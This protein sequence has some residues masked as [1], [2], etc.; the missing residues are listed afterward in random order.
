MVEGDDLIVV[1]D[2]I[3]KAVIEV[4]EEGTEAV[5]VTMVIDTEGCAMDSAERSPPQVN[6]VADHPFAFYIVE[7][8]TGAVVFAGHVLDPS[9]EE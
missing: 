8:A 1:D 7:E 9:K 5:A 3:H 2:I 4:N 6:F